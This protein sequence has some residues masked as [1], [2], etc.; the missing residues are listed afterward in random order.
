MIKPVTFL[1]AALMLHSVIFAQT[2]KNGNQWIDTGIG[3]GFNGGDDHMGFGMLYSIGWQK[4]FKEQ[5]RLRLNPGLSLGTYGTFGI[6]TDTRDQFYNSLAAGVNVDYDLLRY[7][8]LSFVISGGGFVNYS[9]GLLGTGGDPEAHHY[10]RS[11]FF[12]QLYFG[13]NASLG[14]RINNPDSRVAYEYKL[15]GIQGGFNHFGGIYSAFKLQWKLGWDDA[16]AE[17]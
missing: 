4:N 9:Y 10:D 12:N 1:L 8:S 13:G 5:N 17:H 6:P 7:E 11:E 16:D 3:V 14:L 15:L 2:T